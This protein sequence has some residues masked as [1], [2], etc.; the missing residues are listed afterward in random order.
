MQPFDILLTVFAKAPVPGQV[1]TRLAGL[2]GEEAAAHLAHTFLVDTWAKVRGLEAVWPI[3]ATT[4]PLPP[5]PPYAG[6]TPWLQG[7]GDLGERMERMLRKGLQLAPAAACLGADVP[8]LP[9]GAL[10]AAVALL[11]GHD[12]VLCP[13]EDGG[14]YF[15][16]L[17][18]CPLRLLHGLPWSAADTF[19]R[20]RAR[21][22]SCGLDVAVGPR[23][24]D[25]DRPEDLRALAGR[26]QAD[27]AAAPATA[28]LLAELTLD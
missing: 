15:I 10:A 24:A 11:R 9:P 19:A 20:T 16:G 13:A 28:A 23:W 4:G 2:V 17:R 27:P 14:F 18:R 22:V 8:D 21:L 12:A 5:V 1:K 26:L 6:E 7:E 3:L 25:V